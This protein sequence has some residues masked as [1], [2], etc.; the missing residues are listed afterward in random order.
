MNI[1]FTGKTAIVTGAASGIGYAIAKQLAD[2]GATVVVADLKEDKANAAAKEISE[3][4]F[5]FA[6]DVS[7][8]S[9]VQ[10]L[11]KF[12]VDQTGRLDFLVNNAGIGGAS[13]SVGEYPTDSWRQVI[14]VNLNG[15][16]YGM[17]YAIPALK[18]SGG[19]AIVNI[20]SILGSVGIENS[21]AYVAAKHGV[22]GLTKSAALEHAVDNIR[23]TAVGPGFIHTP[24]VDQTLDDATQTALAEKHAQKRLGT[25]EE[26]ASLVTYLLSDQASFVTGSYHLVDG[27]YTAQ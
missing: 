2:S 26:V 25:P 18:E 24:L 23:V 21:S 7:D 14:D 22:I 19:G 9:S 15:V 12:A 3:T 11:V 17:R 13:A 4:A 6:A 5:G 20:A 10:G 1:D 8:E 27:G 16:F